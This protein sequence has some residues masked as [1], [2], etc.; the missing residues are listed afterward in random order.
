MA[1]VCT[2]GAAAGKE[3]GH[4]APPA[5]TDYP[6]AV[7]LPGRLKS[8]TLG[9]LLGN[10][11]R[12][13]ACGQLELVGRDSHHCGCRHWITMRDGLVCDV[14]TAFPVPTL[15]EVLA[16]QGN[17]TAAQHQRLVRALPNDRSLMTGELL[18]RDGLA[19]ARDIAIALQHQSRLRI[20]A[21]YALRD[22]DI[23][24]HPLKGPPPPQRLAPEVFLHGRERARDKQEEARQNDAL[25]LAYKT[26]GLAPG[27]SMCEVRRAFR[28][29]AL[30][31]H[32]DLH[33]QRSAVDQQQQQVRFA[34]LSRAYHTIIAKA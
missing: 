13:K 7:F 12:A 1:A 32:P 8:T 14:T 5:L 6:A 21:V 9:D 2:S 20:D 29:L 10:L 18:I 27:A 17:L 28:R 33:S 26:L 31:D 16:Q 25:R 34:T 30:S 23:R 22:A 24:F 11:H 19:T 4:L 15:G 3:T